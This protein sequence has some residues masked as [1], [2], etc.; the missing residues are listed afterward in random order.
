MIVETEWKKTLVEVYF[1]SVYTD[2]EERKTGLQ[3]LQLELFFKAKTRKLGILEAEIRTGLER[4][5]NWN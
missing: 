4:Q 3:H 5:N 2:K 1:C